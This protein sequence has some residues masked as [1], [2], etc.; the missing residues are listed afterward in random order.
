M[1][2]LVLNG[3]PKKA[4]DTMRLTHS[5]VQ[6]MNGNEN[7]EVE[8][9]DVIDKN[10]G[11]CLGCFGCWKLNEGRCVQ[12]DDMNTILDKIKQSDIII[13]S[14]PLYFYGMPSHIKAVL[15]RTLPLVKMSM[16]S[17]NGQIVHD[18]LVDMSNKQYVVLSGCGFPHWEGNFDSLIKQCQNSFKR[19]LTM[20]CVPETPMLNVKAAEP[21]ATALLKKFEDAGLEYSANL[22]LSEKTTATL[23]T[24]MLPG[25]IYMQIVNAQK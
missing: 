24:P 5:F 2:I 19:N 23:Q 18:A 22:S 15:D 10:I 11:P 8:I 7:H 12:N 13:W 6:G 17:M 25:D 1:K 3:S 21:L 20:I 14:F 9:I 16:K 4:S